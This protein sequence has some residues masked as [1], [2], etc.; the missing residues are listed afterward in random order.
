M[1][2]GWDHRDRTEVPVLAIEGIGEGRG[3]ETLPGTVIEHGRGAK[4]G[5]GEV[6]GL[7]GFWF[8]RWRGRLKGGALGGLWRLRRFLRPWSL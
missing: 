8:L 4:D 2:S 7:L 5:R 1:Y 6:C 3:T